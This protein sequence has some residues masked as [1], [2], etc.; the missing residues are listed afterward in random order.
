[1]L[2]YSLKLAAVLATVGATLAIAGDDY[3]NPLAR[4]DATTAPDGVCD[5]SKAG[6]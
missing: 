5:G 3:E 1:M 4:Y 6:S 2:T